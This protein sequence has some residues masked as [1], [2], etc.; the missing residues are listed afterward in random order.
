MPRLGATP[1]EARGQVPAVLSSYLE[2]RDT[3]LV[4]GLVEEKLKELCARFLAGEP[5]ETQ[6]E[7]DRAA[8]DWAYAIAWDSDRAD[9]LLWNRLHRYFSERELVEL[10]YATAFMLGQQHWVRTLGLRPEIPQA[11]T[12][13]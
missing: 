10:G 8:L 4:N 9:P 13:S 12:T 5:V 11:E 6:D 2:T 1:N 7:R 3:V